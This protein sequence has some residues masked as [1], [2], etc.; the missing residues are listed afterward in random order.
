MRSKA[1]PGCL[2][3]GYCSPECQKIDWKIHELLC[4]YM[5]ISKSKSLSFRDLR[6]KLC[7]LDQLADMNDGKY[8]EIQISEFP[9]SYSEYQYDD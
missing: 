6:L 9:L 7:E 4:P 8:A 1:C 3:T 5:K 2:I